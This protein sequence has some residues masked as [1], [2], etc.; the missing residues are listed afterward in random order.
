MLAWA[1][2]TI[3]R[4]DLARAGGILEELDQ[5]QAVD[6]IIELNRRFHA[7]LYEPCGRAR[8]LALVETLRRNFARYLRFTWESTQHR[9]RSQGQHRQLLRL[10]AAGKV[11]E[12]SAHLRAHI[13]ETGQVIAKALRDRAP[14]QS[15]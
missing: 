13:G 14:V 1:I 10:I 2:P 3:A 8:S 15:P 12:A 9:P 7:I 11:A 6:R 4:A 5:A